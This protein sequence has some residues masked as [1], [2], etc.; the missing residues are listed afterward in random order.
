MQHGTRA[1]P[2]LFLP[3]R[4]QK[5]LEEP[6]FKVFLT[7]HTLFFFWLSLISARRSG[8][9]RLWRSGIPGLR[10]RVGQAPLSTNCKKT[11][12]KRTTAL[13]CCLKHIVYVAQP[14]SSLCARFIQLA[15]VIRPSARP[16]TKHLRWFVR[17][18]VVH[19]H[20]TQCS[21]R[22]SALASG[23]SLNLLCLEEVFSRGN[24]A[25]C[26]AHLSCW[27]SRKV[28]PNDALVE[29][30]QVLEVGHVP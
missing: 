10:A 3:G 19:G 24:V 6:V 26:K 12:K 15:Q 11:N 27:P 18:A 17:E 9:S 28:H 23:H 29:V 5:R 2:Q 30:H 8:V 7:I 20:P 22:M 16:R 13:H 14:H 4:T 25:K 21:Q 1:N